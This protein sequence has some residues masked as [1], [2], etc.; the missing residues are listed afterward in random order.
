MSLKDLISPQPLP[1]DFEEWKQKPFPTRVRML[2]TAW[3][4]PGYCAPGS[5][6]VSSLS[7]ARHDKNAFISGVKITGRR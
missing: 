6:G 7:K 1:F 5:S 4:T 2:C 3:A